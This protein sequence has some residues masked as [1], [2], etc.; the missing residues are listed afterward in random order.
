MST[1]T[2]TLSIPVK[3]I[4]PDGTELAF[5]PKHTLVP[6]KTLETY[7]NLIDAARSMIKNVHD[8]KNNGDPVVLKRYWD[9]VTELE[10]SLE[11]FP[12]DRRSI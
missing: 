2:P 5:L 4:G 12:V 3:F 8:S 6:D 11:S 10:Q 1:S 7:K 9:A